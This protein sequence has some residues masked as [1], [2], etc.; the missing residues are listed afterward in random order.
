MKTTKTNRKMAALVLGLLISTGLFLACQSTGNVRRD[1]EAVQA[2]ERGDAAFMQGDFHEAVY[3]YE[4]AIE[5]EPEWAE[6]FIRLGNAGLLLGR[7]VLD[8]Y[9]FIDDYVDAAKIDPRY[10]DFAD[11]SEH[12]RNENYDLAIEI[13]N[14]VIRNNINLVAAYTLRG[15]IYHYVEKNYDMAISDFT[16][17][18]R[19]QPC[20]Y[21]YLRRAIVYF[22]KN[23]NSNALA[24]LTKSI[25]LSNNSGYDLHNIEAYMMRG[26]YAAILGNPHEAID[27]FSFIIDI[28]YDPPL[29]TYTN[30]AFC[31]LRLGDYNKAMTD[32]N[33]VLEI[34]PSNVIAQEAKTEIIF[35]QFI[36][37]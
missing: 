35:M 15:E 3:E 21:L 17:A 4:W 36:S 12:Y 27:D 7:E 28:H 9:S 14:R 24:D 34:D 13:F 23:D 22:D 20:F 10:K 19:L 18:I 16:E 1:S 30:R 26:T 8:Y 32:I 5:I 31:Y 6:A 11:A 25:E 29:H 37:Q 2:F 33:W